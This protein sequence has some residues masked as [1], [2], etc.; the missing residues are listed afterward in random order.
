MS[1]VFPT[2]EWNQV[3][4]WGRALKQHRAEI[5]D[6]TMKYQMREREMD[7]SVTGDRKVCRPFTPGMQE[8]ITFILTRFDIAWRKNIADHED[9]L[10]VRSTE[11][12][13]EAYGNWHTEAQQLSKETLELFR[14]HVQ[15]FGTLEEP[16]A[17][18]TAE[19]IAII[20]EFPLRMNFVLLCAPFMTCRYGP[21]PRRTPL[22]GLE[23]YA[24]E[25]RLWNELE[26]V[27]M[28][29]CS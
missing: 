29:V 10:G 8:F 12:E 17:I 6:V 22:L 27:T 4:R 20:K 21:L 14:Q 28:T 11:L 18:P 23:S 7:K 2:L 26:P 24:A 19:D 5:D 15:V 13:Q 16:C 25:V 9:L 1:D 3:E